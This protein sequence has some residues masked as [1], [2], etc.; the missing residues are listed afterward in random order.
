MKYHQNT[1]NSCCLSS[2][3]SAFHFIGDKRDVPYNISIIEESLNLQIKICKN[4]II[5]GND[6][7]KTLREKRKDEHNLRYNRTIWKKNDALYILNN[8]H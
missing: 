3:T 4:I 2:L 7:M 6:I 8:I 1:Y 5:F